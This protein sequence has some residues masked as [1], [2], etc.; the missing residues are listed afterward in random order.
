MAKFSFEVCDD[1]GPAERVEQELSDISAVRQKAVSV[2]A[3][4]MRARPDRLW[5]AGDI[6]ITARD[7]ED[8]ALLSVV[9]VGLASPATRTTR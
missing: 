7:E 5:E 8:L 2:A 4:V 1:R 6:T 3:D 9:V